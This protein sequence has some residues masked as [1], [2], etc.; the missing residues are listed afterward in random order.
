MQ[1][2]VRIGGPAWTIVRPTL[3]YDHGGGQELLMYLAYLKRFPVVPFIG[4]GDAKKRPVWAEDV[5][6]G[7]ARIAGNPEAYGK[8]YSLSGGESISTF[9]F[10]W[11]MK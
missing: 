8:T 9:P 2:F 6:D 5:V 3:V 4:K 7:L 10:G 1:Q 11:V